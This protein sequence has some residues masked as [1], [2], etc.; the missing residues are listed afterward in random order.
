MESHRASTVQRGQPELA[1]RAARDLRCGSELHVDH[2][3][4]NRIDGVC[5]TQLQNLRER[6]NSDRRRN[7]L[8]EYPRAQNSSRM[9][10]HHQ[11]VCPETAT[12]NVK[13]FLSGP[14]GRSASKRGPSLT[15]SQIFTSGA[16][17]GK[18]V[19]S[20]RKLNSLWRC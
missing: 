7:G 13:L 2:Q 1:R 8:A 9:E 5:E 12:Q 10:L 14:L 18:L 19:T 17:V 20:K 6:S 11:A 3:D 16:C 15:G 4:Q